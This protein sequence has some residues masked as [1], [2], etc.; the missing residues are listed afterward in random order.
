MTTAST[1]G[2]APAVAGVRH[3]PPGSGPAVWVAGDTYTFKAIGA[4]TGGTLTVWEADVPPGAGPPPHAHRDQDEA[5]Y[6]LDGELEVRDGN[7][8]FTARA[9]AFVFIP[10]G[11]VHAF[12]NTGST[13]ARMLLWMTPSGFEEFLFAVGQPAR[14]GESAPP[15]GPDEIAR[16]VAIADRYGLVLATG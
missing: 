4:E 15:L 2:A 1:P 5:Y 14:P 9:G 7:R 16:T 10:R 11:A 3:V 13:P 12:R 8:T 6:I